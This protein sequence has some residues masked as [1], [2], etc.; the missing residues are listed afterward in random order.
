MTS[1]R[2]ILGLNPGVRVSSIKSKDMYRGFPCDQVENY[3]P[4]SRIPQDSGT[5]YGLFSFAVDFQSNAEDG[6]GQ[7]MNTTLDLTGGNA[8]TFCGIFRLDAGWTPFVLASQWGDVPS[9]ENSWILAPADAATYGAGG[10]GFRMWFQNGS[11]IAA[12]QLNLSPLPPTGSTVQIVVRYDGSAVA[13]SDRVR[14]WYAINS[15]ASLTEGSI[16]IFD[17]F[18]PSEIPTSLQAST[19]DTQI[20]GASY[21]TAR[22]LSGLFYDFAI[23]NI[24]LTPTQILSLRSNGYLTDPELISGITNHWRFG[25]NPSDAGTTIVDSIGSFN[26]TL[27]NEGNPAT[28]P[29]IVSV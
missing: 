12:A 27:T 11:T 4:N 7:K 21:S 18:G 6:N 24:L 10:D 28:N 8:Y 13:E 23:W 29:T 19:I 20:G 1:R 17:P 15:D 5:P 22:G 25:N 9:T 16:T 26:G 2:S 3:G 14:M